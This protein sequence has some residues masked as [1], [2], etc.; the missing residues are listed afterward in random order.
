M[1]VQLGACELAAPPR[2]VRESSASVSVFAPRWHVKNVT[3]TYYF[4]MYNER[5][6]SISIKAIA[7][8]R[9]L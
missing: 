5:R 9:L 2:H 4:L 8:H 1:E 3:C 6:D 7:S